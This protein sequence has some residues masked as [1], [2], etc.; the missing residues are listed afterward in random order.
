MSVN[1]LNNYIFLMRSYN[2]T[3]GVQQQ[4]KLKFLD[5]KHYKQQEVQFKW[6]LNLNY[7]ETQKRA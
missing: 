2:G 3:V 1:N 4:D 7:S 6:F 5:Y